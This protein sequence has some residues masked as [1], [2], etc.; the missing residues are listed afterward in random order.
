MLLHGQLQIIAHDIWTITVWVCL[1]LIFAYLTTM[2]T[3]QHCLKE[4]PS[5]LV[6]SANIMHPTYHLLLQLGKMKCFSTAS[7]PA[8]S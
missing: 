4:T 7:N 5:L 6:Q 8:G 3:T 1:T 2:V